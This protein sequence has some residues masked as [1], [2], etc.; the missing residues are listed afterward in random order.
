MIYSIVKVKVKVKVKKKQ[1]MYR[2]KQAL[3][4]PGG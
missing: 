3:R 1:N 2:P 4:S